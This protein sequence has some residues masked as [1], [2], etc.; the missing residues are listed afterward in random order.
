MDGQLKE[1]LSVQISENTRNNFFN[2]LQAVYYMLM[3]KIYH[4]V[5]FPSLVGVHKLCS[6]LHIEIHV[7]V[8]CHL[9]HPSM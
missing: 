7:R 1:V 4:S 5:G 8:R 2:V 6:Q 3:Y 9:R